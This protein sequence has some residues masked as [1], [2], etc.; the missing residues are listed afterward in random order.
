MHES[1][2]RTAPAAIV[3][4]LGL[5]LLAAAGCRTE[6]RMMPMPLVVELAGGDPAPDE[7]DGSPLPPIRIFYA[8]DRLPAEDGEAGARYGSGRGG[9]VR[10]GEAS[11]R[12]GPPEWSRAEFVRETAAGERPGLALVGMREYGV[13]GSAD[14]PKPA[15]APASLSAEGLPGDAGLHFASLIDH[16]LDGCAGR[17]LYVYVPGFNASFE[18]GV[19]R[20]AEFAHYLGG[21]GVF[22]IYGWPAHAHPFS[23]NTD[24]RSA[25]LSGEHFREFLRYLT[26]STDADRIHLVAS[27]AGAPVVSSALVAMREEHA[28]LSGAEARRRT[29]LGQVVYAASDQ[30]VDGFRELLLSGADELAEHITVYSS[31]VD[32]GLI[33][34]RHFGSGDRT[35]GRL[36]VHLTEPDAELLRSR[37][38]TVTVVDATR[39]IEHAGRGDIWAHAYW[40]RNPWVSGDLISLLRHGLPPRDR[41]LEPARDGALWVFPDDYPERLRRS[42]EDCPMAAQ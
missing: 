28:D 14:A 34:T 38:A 19:R 9:V 37:A 30:D 25:F 15:A 35:I 31:S 16:R 24:R 39:A 8:T 3:L 22:V 13:L 27:S 18:A 26:V 42:L 17:D 7:P 11:V 23:Y 32:I 29:R 12:L 40:Y 6:K 41:S 36:P 2:S 21:D 10:V 4:A 33:L 20:L 5:A 1:P